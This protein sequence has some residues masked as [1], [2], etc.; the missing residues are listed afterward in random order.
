MAVAARPACTEVHSASRT[1]WLWKALSNQSRV[2]PGGGHVA[3]RR[4]LKA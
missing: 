3:V 2:K 1:P 4:S